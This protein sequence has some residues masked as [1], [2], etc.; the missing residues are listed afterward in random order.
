M[1]IFEALRVI[2]SNKNQ[3]KNREKIVKTAMATKTKQ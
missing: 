3:R 2:D 1:E